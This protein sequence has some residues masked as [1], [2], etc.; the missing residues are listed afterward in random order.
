MKYVIIGNSAAAVGA[1]EGIRNIDANGAI[2]VISDE[3]Y[4]TYSR[5]LISYYL[6]NKTNKERM[7]YREH[8]FY[9]K[10][11]CVSL[12]GRSVTKIDPSKNVIVLD[13][14]KKERYDKLLLATGSSPVIPPIKGLENVKDKY[15]FTKFD[16]AL[17]IEKAVNTSSRVL[18][19]GAGLIG[20]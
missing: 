20:L 14:A 16:D 12:L 15:T 8:N 18:I 17:A 10:N 19:L 1:I 13:N 3:P 11:N 4:H 6:Q 7:R 2:T 9:E 5:P